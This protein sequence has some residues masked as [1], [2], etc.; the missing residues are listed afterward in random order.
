VG[1]VGA[2]QLARMLL[3]AALPLGLDVRLLA[4]RADDSAALVSTAVSLGSPRSFGDLGCFVAGN[5]VTTFDHELVDAE[6]LALLENAGHA[7]RPSAAVVG[8]VQDKR[9]QRA[10]LAERGFPIREGGQGRLRRPRRLGAEQ[11]R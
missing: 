3:E 1:V 6:A 11:R 9:I 7:I 5:L 2:G 4:E 8:L 10:V